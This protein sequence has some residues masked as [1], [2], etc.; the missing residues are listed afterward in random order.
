M[1]YEP[2]IIVGP[3]VNEAD[4]GN[5]FYKQLSTPV[6]LDDGYRDKLRWLGSQCSRL[7]TLIQLIAQSSDGDVTDS[8][9]LT[10][11]LPTVIQFGSIESGLRLEAAL[12]GLFPHIARVEL[13]NHFGGGNPGDTVMYTP[14]PPPQPDGQ[15]SPIGARWPE[16]DA[17]VGGVA[18]RPALDNPMAK[19]FKEGDVYS[20]ATGNYRLTHIWVPFVYAAVWVK[21]S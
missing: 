8:N 13:I 1:P 5:G 18:Y 3:K 11:D 15:P 14:P 7:P 4:L 9:G 10:A 2:S 12:V 17:T 6:A 19:P 16:R 21:V 20:D